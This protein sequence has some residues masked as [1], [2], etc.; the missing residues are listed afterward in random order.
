LAEE[1]VRV[2]ALFPIALCR[3]IEAGALDPVRR[4]LPQVTEAVDDLPSQQP[5]LTV[6]GGQ[7]VHDPEALTPF[8]SLGSS[9]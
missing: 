7:P 5:V 2:S 6:V 8:E 4:L 3:I 9:R 1:G